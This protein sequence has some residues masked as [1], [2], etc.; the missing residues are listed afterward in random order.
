VGGRVTVRRPAVVVLVGALLVAATGCGGG[1]QSEP[2]TL[3]QDAVPFGLLDEP[4]STVPPTTVPV[5]KYP[6]VVYFVGPDGPIPVVRTSSE[7]PDP[8][9]V[10][11]ALSIGPTREE[12]QVGMDSYVPRRAIGDISDVKRRTVT[13]DLN[14]P[15]VDVSGAAQIRALTQIVL[16]MTSLRGVSQ[17]RFL[18]D[19]EPVSVP[20]LNGTVTDAPVKRG[21][22]QPRD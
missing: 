19:G 4:T 11:R 3:N 6:F 20:R 10:G 13:I 21:D 9:E 8:N 17:V 2:E 22:Y 7:R 1:S 16:T 18:L 5:R 15:F 14:P 12:V